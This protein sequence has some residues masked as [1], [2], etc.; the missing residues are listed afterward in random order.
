MIKTVMSIYGKQRV[1]EGYN[2]HARVYVKRQGSGK[3]S[4]YYLSTSFYP[5]LDSMVDVGGEYHFATLKALKAA[6]GN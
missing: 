1:I 5:S 2:G 3:R 4:S 6:L